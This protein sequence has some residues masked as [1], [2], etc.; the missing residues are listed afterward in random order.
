MSP[1]ACQLGPSQSWWAPFVIC[2]PVGGAVNTKSLV[3]KHQCVPG[4][5]WHLG[6]VTMKFPFLTFQRSVS[7]CSVF[8]PINCLCVGVYAPKETLTKM[9]DIN[10]QFSKPVKH[11]KKN[12]THGLA[13]SFHVSPERHVGIL[14]LYIIKTCTLSGRALLLCVL[15]I[16]VL[17]S[18][19]L[20]N[21]MTLISWPCCWGPSSNNQ[22]QPR[23]NPEPDKLWRVQARQSSLQP[24]PEISFIHP[25]FT[26][27][28]PQ[29]SS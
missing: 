4:C 14:M 1:H 21:Q 29:A 3:L 24:T 11:C 26:V 15:I 23:H 2:F 12:Y 7:V 16:H 17:N 20:F 28:C 10:Y 18:F 5:E 9:C 13:E 8:Q 25:H 22:P 19:F 27:L 6:I